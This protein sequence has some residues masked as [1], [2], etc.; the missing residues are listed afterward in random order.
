MKPKRTLVIGDV[1]GCIDELTELLEKMGYQ[2]PED[3]LVFV[4]DL[5]NKGPK[6][7]EVLD[8]VQKHHAIVTMGNHEL[9]FLRAME[10]NLPSSPKL[11]ELKVQMGANLPMW[12]NTLRNFPPFWENEHCLVVHGGLVPGMD[13]KNT[14]LHMLATIRTWDGIGKD[15]QN[16]NN[17]P[18]YDSFENTKVKVFGHWAARGLVDLPHALGLDTGC[19]YG[20]KLTGVIL[21]ERT[22]YQVQAR[23]QYCSFEET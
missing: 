3:D 9:K 1:H 15:L 22:L 8:F 7:L 4:G 21:P 13:P 5:I 16:P 14:P 2:H 6:S 19:V 12:L 10:Q 20:R 23:K 17:P 18:W 11:N